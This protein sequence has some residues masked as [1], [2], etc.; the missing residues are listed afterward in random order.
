MD[1][2]AVVWFHD[3]SR[4]ARHDVNAEYLHERCPA[5]R[6]SPDWRRPLCLGGWR[7]RYAGARH[8]LVGRRFQAVDEDTSR[9]PRRF[10]GTALWRVA[11]DVT[12]ATP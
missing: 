6:T 5:R 7:R 4:G 10:A 9:G 11:R 8:R 1:I 12:T 2:R 3:A